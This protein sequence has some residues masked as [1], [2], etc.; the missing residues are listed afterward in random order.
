M[1]TAHRLQ[2]YLPKEDYIALKKRAQSE[3]M[4]LAAAVREAVHAYLARSKEDQIREGYAGM[5]GL[6][7]IGWDVEGKTDVSERHD[8]YLD[9]IGEAERRKWHGKR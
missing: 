9:K 4:P 5:M 3:D 7:G 8:Q 6:V 2:I 1:M